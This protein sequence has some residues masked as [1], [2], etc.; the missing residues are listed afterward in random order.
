MEK[1]LPLLPEWL[2]F[3]RVNARARKGVEI[4]PARL[5]LRYEI[6]TIKS[7]LSLKVK[8]M[9]CLHFQ[10][11]QNRLSYALPTLIGSLVVYLV[12]M[13]WEI[14]LP[15]KLLPLVEQTV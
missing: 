13:W 3:T 11:Q 12:V 2:S 8:G 14:S 4:G 7:T 9:P 5:H 15:M 1:G 6:H 10:L